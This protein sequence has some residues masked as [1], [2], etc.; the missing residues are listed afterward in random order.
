MSVQGSHTTS[1][2]MGST[3]S[4]RGSSLR[5]LRYSRRL[6]RNSLKQRGQARRETKGEE[7]GREERAKV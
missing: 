7:E 4:P 5:L 1:I 6:R 3:S 2:G